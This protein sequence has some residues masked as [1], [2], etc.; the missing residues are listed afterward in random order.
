MSGRVDF[1]YVFIWHSDYA[2]K[3]NNL[4]F[5]VNF[6]L[7]TLG[8]I[9]RLAR[10]SLFL[11]INSIVFDGLHSAKGRIFITKQITV[12]ERLRRIKWWICRCV[13]DMWYITCRPIESTVIVRIYCGNDYNRHKTRD[14]LFH[15]CKIVA[16]H[17]F[18]TFILKI[19]RNTFDRWI[20]TSH[21]LEVSGT[22]WTRLLRITIVLYKQERTF[23]N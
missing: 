20:Y 19:F 23:T 17:F 3:K 16:E 6:K 1:I 13:Y 21:S 2:I 18:C 4:S 5:F 7:L 9:V 10:S 14:P 12:R 15:W 22:V 8:H 11:S